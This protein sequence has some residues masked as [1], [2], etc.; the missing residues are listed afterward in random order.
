MTYGTRHGDFIVTGVLFSLALLLGGGSLIFPI[1]RMI[2][3]LVAVFALGWFLVRGWRAERSLSAKVGIG[4]VALTFALILVQLV[5]LPP[6]L[7]Q[8]LPGRALPASV[9]AVVGEGDR[10]FPISLDAAATWATVF[11]FLVPAALFIATL[12]LD[13]TGQRVLLMVFVVFALL[14]AV[15]VALQAQGTSAL[16]MYWTTESRPGFGL[17]ANKNHCAVMLVIAMPAAAMLC[18]D[19]LRG[20]SPAAQYLA[21]GAI[22]ALLAVTV[23]GCLSRAGLALLPVGL[24]A[25]LLILVRRRMSPRTLMITAAIFVALLAL[26]YVVLPRTHIVAEALNRFNADREG[27]YDFWPDVLRAIGTYFPI[28]SGLGTFVP[29]FTAHETL[30]NVHQTYTN[31]AHSDYL[32]IMLETGVA[33]VA[34]VGA[35]FAWFAATTWRRLRDNWS[36]PGFNMIVVATTAILVLLIHSGLDYP[37]RTLTLAGMMAICAAILASPAAFPVPASRRSGARAGTSRHRQ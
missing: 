34:L 3:E 12:H 37:L 30:E 25:A 22:L 33:G 32:E 5:P 4:I 21:S 26:A 20:R 6:A 27:R 16:T 24:L 13:R 28:G 10:W 19:L 7:W 31:H 35:F 18:Q 17:F 29:V 36:G 14:N 8:S 11:Y 1:H 2:V 15:L 9:L 23:F